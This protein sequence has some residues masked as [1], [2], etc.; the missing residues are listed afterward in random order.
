MHPRIKVLLLFPILVSCHTRGEQN[1]YNSSYGYLVSSFSIV[2]P[3]EIFPNEVIQYSLNDTSLEATWESED[4]NILSI[5]QSGLATAHNEGD[6]TIYAITSKGTASVNISVRRRKI[7]PSNFDELQEILNYAIDMESEASDVSYRIEKPYSETKKISRTVTVYE[8][9]Y[10]SKTLEESDTTTENTSEYVGIKNDYFYSLSLSES[11]SVGLK[12]KIV[13]D[14]DGIITNG[15]I[16]VEEA[17]ERSTNPGYLQYFY[18]AIKPMWSESTTNTP[19]F[20]THESKNGFEVEISSSSLHVYGDKVGNDYTEYTL[21]LSFSDNGFLTHGSYSIIN[22]ASGQYDVDKGKLKDNPKIASEEDALYTATQ[23]PFYEDSNCEIDPEDYFVSKVNKAVYKNE[24]G[25]G[26]YIYEKNILL[27]DYES[28]LSLDVDSVK[29]ESIESLDGEDCVT[30]SEYGYYQ[31]VKEGNILLH[32]QMSYSSDV[33]FD[34]EVTIV[35][36]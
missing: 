17:K 18:Y 27:K 3:K 6:T 31:A 9:S 11:Y 25:V 5:T 29:I 1:S 2:G 14:G 28:E 33:T 22:Y 12:K 30:M 16:D 8:N 10:L 23:A 34:V 4:S 19:V 24:L 15:E 13:E 7:L 36:N 21:F 20:K 32:C 26:D 35:D